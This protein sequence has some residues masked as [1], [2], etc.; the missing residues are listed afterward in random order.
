MNRA[1]LLNEAG[2]AALVVSKALDMWDAGDRRGALRLM[3]QD[4][5]ERDWLTTFLGAQE[6]ITATEAE[7]LLNDVCSDDA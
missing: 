2:T 6:G 4:G 5:A 7:A 3:H 1:E